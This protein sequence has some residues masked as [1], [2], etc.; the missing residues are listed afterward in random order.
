MAMAMIGLITS[1]NLVLTA[2]NSPLYSPDTG[3]LKGFVLGGEDKEILIGAMVQIEGKNRVEITDED[4]KFKL[5][6]IPKGTVFF[7]K[8]GYTEG[9]YLRYLNGVILLGGETSTWTNPEL[10]V[11]NFRPV[12]FAE[13]VVR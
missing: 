7:G 3:S 10:E 12:N 8:V 9:V 1:T 11:E 13:L 2:S 4:G 5:K 6:D